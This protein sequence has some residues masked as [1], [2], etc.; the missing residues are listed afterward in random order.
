MTSKEFWQ[1]FKDFFKY[2]LSFYKVRDFFYNLKWFFK[3]LKNFRKQLWDFRSWD[4]S[5][6]VDMYICCLE[7]IANSIENGHEEERSAAKKV[8]KIRELIELLRYSNERLDDELYDLYDKL[9]KEGKTNNEIAAESY[10]FYFEFYEKI[11]TILKGQDHS[12]I[13][14]KCDAI[15]EEKYNGKNYPHDEWYDEYVNL[16]DGSGANEW[17]D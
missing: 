4:H 9:R 1:N 10:K 13:C 7:Q 17:W 11:F 12:V 8:V 5:H 6:A 16:F 3:N 2:D 15:L 14:R